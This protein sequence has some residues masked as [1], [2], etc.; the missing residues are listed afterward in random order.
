MALPGTDSQPSVQFSLPLNV[1]QNVDYFNVFQLYGA[2]GETIPEVQVMDV[3]LLQ[4]ETSI[5]TG[6]IRDIP[7]PHPSGT[8]YPFFLAFMYVTSYK[9][10]LAWK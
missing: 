1:E 2:S 9:S 8:S 5:A 4:D 7:Q 10:Y 3:E 6:N